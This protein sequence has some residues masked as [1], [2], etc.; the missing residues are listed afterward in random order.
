MKVTY[1]QAI[2]DAIKEEMRRDDT[3]IVYGEDV[4]E[5]GGIFTVT[6]GI[7]EEFGPER[8]ISTPISETA[9]VGSA[10]G[11]AMT[12]L[13]PV[14]EL[15]YNDFMLVAF[16]ELFHS[17]GKWRYIHGP[18]YQ[19]PMVVRTAGGH[20]FGAGPEHSSSFES[21]FMHAP[22]VKIAVPSCAYDAKGLMKT[23]IRD[24]N[25]VLFFEHKLLYKTKEE[26][27]DEDYSIPFG[28]ADIKRIGKDATI[29]AV[30]YMV[31]KA[32]EAATELEK[33]GISVE[34]IDPRTLAPLDKNTIYD[35][36]RKT[37]RAV[38]VEES[39]L[40]N[41]IGAELAALIQEDIFDELDGPVRRVAALDVPLPYNVGLE[42]HSIP[43]MER[44][45]AAVKSLF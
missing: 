17:G 36:I 7:L 27:P 32:L 2:G 45:A 18:E 19:V 6:K 9:I 35:S 14:V 8:I 10:I 37:H 31:T 1:A 13:R 33:D 25:E 11:A 41:G 39:N 4:A 34:V 24:D 23:A 15:M 42:Q 12:G 16:N 44:I 28:L 29:I 21:L 38:V 26:I 22:G 30:G 20:S 3:I 40:T 43:S 5:M